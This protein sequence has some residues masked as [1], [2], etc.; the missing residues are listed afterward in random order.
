MNIIRIV[1]E[2]FDKLFP[3][4]NSRKRAIEKIFREA[5][6]RG[7]VR[8]NAA[9]GIGLFSSVKMGRAIF[10]ESL[11]EL[12][13][14]RWLEVLG[15]V[16][17]FKEQP[18]SIQYEFEGKL[19]KY[20]PDFLVQYIEGKIEVWE[21]KPDKFKDKELSRQLFAVAEAIFAEYGIRF[22]IMT[23][24]DLPEGAE[25]FNIGLFIRYRNTRL[26]SSCNLFTGCSGQT[27]IIRD[28]VNGALG[29]DIA[30]AELIVMIGQGL[31]GAD[32]SQRISQDTIVMVTDEL[33]SEAEKQAS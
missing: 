4:G 28:L 12:D 27:F 31:L 2:Y 14:V 13:A 24:T 8:K 22:R 16:K 5:P 3:R 10:W 9:R 17:R 18:F 15:S 20:T 7:N 26:S 19:R 32:M 21:V 33:A 11:L 29:Q 1:I 25:K 23:E 6:V 30:F